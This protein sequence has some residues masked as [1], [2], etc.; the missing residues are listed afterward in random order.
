[1]TGLCL[2]PSRLSRHFATAAQYTAC[3]LIKVLGFPAPGPPRLQ[4]P[5]SRRYNQPP[6]HWLQRRVLQLSRCGL[7]SRPSP[8]APSFFLRMENPR[9]LLMHAHHLRW[10]RPCCSELSSCSCWRWLHT[11]PCGCACTCVYAARVCMCVCEL[12]V[13]ALWLSWPHCCPLLVP[14]GPPPGCATTLVGWP[15][16]Y[17]CGFGVATE[18]IMWPQYYWCATK[19]MVWPPVSCGHMPAHNQPTLSHIFT[20][21][22]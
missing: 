13:G 17:L 1:M 12:S 10:S 4:V 16:N 6:H 22:H 8:H 20:S 11:T 3:G 14:C 19:L 7:A 21:V 15:Q 5:R 2:H 18:V 9:L